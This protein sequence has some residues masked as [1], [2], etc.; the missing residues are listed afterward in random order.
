MSKFPSHLVTKRIQ[1]E[2]LMDAA[3]LAA[4]TLPLLL[5][6]EEAFLALERGKMLT[7]RFDRERRNVDWPR[8]AFEDRHTTTLENNTYRIAYDGACYRWPITKFVLAYSI[9]PEVCAP[10][11]NMIRAGLLQKEVELWVLEVAKLA[12]L[13]HAWGPDLVKMHYAALAKSNAPG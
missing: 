8:V 4:E 12:E 5:P 2:I 6:P 1:N 11:R 7:I 3:K 13:S 9:S 10:F